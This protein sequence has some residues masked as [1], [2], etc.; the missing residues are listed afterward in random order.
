MATG[1]ASGWQARWWSILRGFD[2]VVLWLED[3]GSLQL[4]HALL[5]TRPADGPELC[6]AHNLPGPKDPGRILGEDQIHGPDRVVRAIRDARPVE[7]VQDLLRAVVERLRA[8]RSGR[9]YA[10]HCPL[11]G[12]RVPSLSIF[13]GDDG[14]AWRCHAGSCGAAGRLDLLGA[15]LGL[16]EADREAAAPPPAAGRSGGG[17]L[18]LVSAADLLTAPGTESL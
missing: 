1:G 11:H 9:G 3:S 7:I 8:R 16:V 17:Q 14:W 6:V 10:A 15:I 4:L 5:R 18:S 2:R 12:D 13:R